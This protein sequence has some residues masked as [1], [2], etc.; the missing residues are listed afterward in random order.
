MTRLRSRFSLFHRCAAWAVLLSLLAPMA[1]GL[2]NSVSVAIPAFIHLC[3]SE[4]PSDGNKSDK[5]APKTPSC[6]ICQSLHLLSGGIAPPSLAILAHIPIFIGISIFAL[7]I[8]L[9]R[10][11]F[12]P[13]AQPRAPPASLA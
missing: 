3:H 12:T 4:A 5:S 1:L 11:V 6:P 2:A 8:F 10:P 9:V 7:S 13:Q